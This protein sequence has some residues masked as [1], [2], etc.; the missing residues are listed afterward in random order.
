MTVDAVSA[1]E[2]RATVRP[3]VDGDAWVT[4]ELEVC[5]LARPSECLPGSPFSCDVAAAG[6]PSNATQCA[7]TGATA[8]TTYTVLAVA[9]E[10]DGTSS[11][12]SGAVPFTTPQHP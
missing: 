6:S 4:Y 5:E 3:P 1:V 10:A 8:S 7:I 11:E 9:Y 12:V 2:A